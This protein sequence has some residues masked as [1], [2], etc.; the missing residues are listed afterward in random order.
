MTCSSWCGYCGRC[1]DGRRA[2]ASCSAC[3]T[4]FC[5]EHDSTGSLCD[6]CC[7]DR[8]ALAAAAPPR[9]VKVDRPAGAAVLDRPA[10]MDWAGGPHPCCVDYA[11]VV[12]CDGATTTLRCGVCASTF[13]QPCPDAA[14]AAIAE[15]RAS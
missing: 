13:S 2:N 3:G 8:D 10:G 7:D 12:A 14:F 15:G 4:E 1:E 9:M 6:R 5:I 11:Q